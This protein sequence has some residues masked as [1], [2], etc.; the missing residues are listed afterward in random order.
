MTPPR[1]LL[2]GFTGSPESWAAVG[3]LLAGDRVF[4]PALVG[5]DGSPGPAGV[6]CF[7]DEVDR[8]ARE[9]RRQRL[10]G[11]DLVGYSMGARLALGLLVRHAGLFARAVLVGVNPGLSDARE[12][13]ARKSADEEWARLLEVG[14]LD[15]FVA[16]W[17][18]LPLLDAGDRVAPEILARQ[19]RI[20]LSHHPLGLAHALRVTGL[21]GMPDYR[22]ALPTVEVPV[23]VVAGQRDEKFIDLGKETA[24]LL[25]RAR[26][27]VVAGAGH[28]VVLERPAEIARLLKEQEP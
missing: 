26:L 8:L 3:P 23:E 13:E 4:V 10:E 5:H 7:D 14:G 9:I 19:Q 6:R 27:H 11:V 24:R 17:E 21:G 16:A 22:P 20:R 1:V 15:T 18:A 28:N 12:R 25:P 2:H